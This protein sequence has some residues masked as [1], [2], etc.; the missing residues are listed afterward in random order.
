MPLLDS[1]IIIY[2]TR[3]EYPQVRAFIGRE[4]PVVSA[5]TY[6]EVLGF[7]RLADPERQLLSEFFAAA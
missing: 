2:A 6:V 4:A 5:I 7:E 3:P 1:N